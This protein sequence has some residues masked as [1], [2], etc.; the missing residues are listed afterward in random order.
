[1]STFGAPALLNLIS[2]NERRAMVR[3]SNRVAYSNGELVHD[4]GDVGTALGIVISGRVNLYRTRSNGTLVFASAV[5]A[6]QNFGDVVSMTGAKRTHHAVAEGQTI[7]DHF[8]QSQ[9]DRILT[10]HPAITLALYKVASYRLKTAIDML[11]D[12]RMLKTEVRLA[13]MLRR[14]VSAEGSYVVIPAMQDVLCQML[15]LSSV[16]I[17]HALKSLRQ[18]GLIETGYRQITILDLTKFDA[19]LQE[20]DWE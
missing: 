1:M 7:V 5:E 10:D 3:L 13:K 12:A 2:D 16:S 20:N 6:G 11:D 14:M 9:L 4:R 19:W 17:V 8:G 18:L 15:G